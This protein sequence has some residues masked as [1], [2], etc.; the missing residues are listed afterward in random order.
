MP[1]SDSLYLHAFNLLSEF[2]PVR[3]YKI[4]QA[5]PN[6]KAAYE[7]DAKTL[8]SRGIERGIAE[9]FVEFKKTLHL[10]SEW[11]KLNRE[12]IW[13]LSYKDQNYPKLLLEISKPPPLL[14]VKGK[15]E[16]NEEL[17]VAVVGTRKISN[18]GRTVVPFLV[19]PLVKSG[20]TIVS[21]LAYGV[22]S[23][24][25]D[26]GLDVQHDDQYADGD[27]DRA[28][29][30]LLPDPR[31]DLRDG[32]DGARAE[33]RIGDDGADGTEGGLAEQVEFGDGF[34]SFVL[35]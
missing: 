6:F 29:G 17:C 34:H 4:G 2:G 5:F 35:C 7:A 10:N 14:Y 21:G 12:N 16:S 23:A 9:K 20:I 3:L 13:L 24:A 22:D 8:E 33:R 1:F 25:H 11:E 15:M 26:R 18:Y 30:D 31:C 27:R 32:Q 19:E 28:D